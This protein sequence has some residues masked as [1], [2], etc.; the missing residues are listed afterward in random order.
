M[1]KN[2]R[3]LLIGFSRFPQTVCNLTDSTIEWLETEVG[4]KY[5]R[6]TYKLIMIC[7]APGNL[8]MPPRSLTILPKPVIRD[9]L[10]AGFALLVL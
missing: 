4:Q 8:S 9:T 7:T 3:I 5:G 10:S 6:E 1:K 2:I